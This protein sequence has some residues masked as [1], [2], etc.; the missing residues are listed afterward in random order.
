MG[1]ESTGSVLHVYICRSLGVGQFCNLGGQIGP[2]SIGVAV[3]GILE[4]VEGRKPDSDFIGPNGI[5]YGLDHLQWE[6]A[7]LLN[8]A[9]IVIISD[10]D[11]VMEKLVEEIAICS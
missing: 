6:S 3:L 10:V 8:T 9:T 2:V 11:V 4:V 1:A 5:A 7:A